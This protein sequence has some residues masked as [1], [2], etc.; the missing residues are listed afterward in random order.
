MV[1]I[2]TDLSGGSGHLATSSTGNPEIDME[3][4]GAEKMGI[5]YY[6][7]PNVDRGKAYL[8]ERKF[9]WGAYY[10]VYAQVT[11]KSPADISAFHHIY[12]VA[13]VKGDGFPEGLTLSSGDSPTASISIP[14]FSL[15]IPWAFPPLQHGQSFTFIHVK[16]DQPQTTAWPRQEEL[17][18][19]VTGYAMADVDVGW[20]SE[21]TATAKYQYRWRVASA[22]RD[23]AK[24]VDS[25]RRATFGRTRQCRFRRYTDSYSFRKVL[26]HSP[27]LAE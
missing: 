13:S 19:W 18:E 22:N 4:A 23:A 26:S 21:A 2:G 6:P 20:A 11:W 16:H 7:I 9:K 8:Q 14:P 12:A 15:P 1:L 10:Y 24:F 25:Q 27:R 17:N 5:Q 3:S